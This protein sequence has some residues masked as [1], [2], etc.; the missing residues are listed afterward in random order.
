MNDDNW[1]YSADNSK[2]GW[3]RNKATLGRVKLGNLI[4]LLGL[5]AVVLTAWNLFAPFLSFI[6]VLEFWPAFLLEYAPADMSALMAQIVAA[7]VGAIVVWF[8]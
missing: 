7:V 5:I 8:L 6:P 1:K 3:L 2:T 4:R